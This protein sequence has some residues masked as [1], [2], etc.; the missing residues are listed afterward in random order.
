MDT[1]R[2]SG[3]DRERD[4]G[5]G[6]PS[7]VQ[8]PVVLATVFLA[9]M[10]QMLLN[11]I[12]A[13]LSRAMGLK[14]WQIGAVISLSA[15]VL[16]L[17]SP[18]W[19]R[20]SQRIGVKK[21][22]MLSLAGAAVSLALFGL[23]AWAGT[24][25]LVTGGVLFAAI[26]VLRGVAYGATIS[27][28]APSSQAYLVDNT[29]TEAQ[30]LKAM[31]AIGA[32]QGLSA[33]VGG[34]VGGGLGYFFG[35]M[36]PLVVMPLIVLAAIG[37]VGVGFHP[38]AAR[39]RYLEPKKIAYT[40]PRV[41]CYLISGFLLFLAFSS[42]QVLFGFTIQDRFGLGAE[43]TAG[44]TAVFMSV[45]A[46]TMVLTQGVLVPKLPWPSR[47]ILRRGLVVMAI[48]AVMVW[49]TGSYVLLT[50]GVVLFGLGS[51]AAMTGYTAGPTLY[52]NGDEQGSLAGII[53]SNNGVTYAV[54][55]V[56]STALYSINPQA[57]FT[58]VIV[59]AVAAVV[60]AYLHPRLRPDKQKERAEAAAKGQ[61]LAPIA[62]SGT[63]GQPAQ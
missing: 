2:D 12:I 48:S 38:V 62:N 63:G 43:Q 37:Y 57:A 7:R 4:N 44:M 19:G 3:N 45:M 20:T 54:A 16:A 6:M 32:A 46:V 34:L 28:V 52:L 30:R 39:G 17:L 26:A 23:V 9:Y 8:A 18:K 41:M 14:A 58:F 24:T 1:R 49:P 31:G 60:F 36:A 51:G 27:A 11:P 25:G 5:S 13:P 40:D 47:V 55:P 56:I 33:I 42:L 21:V 29:T 35:L 59:L 22:L 50:V 61:T 53:N 15:V 10:G